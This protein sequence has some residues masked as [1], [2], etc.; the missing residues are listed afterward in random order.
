MPGIYNYLFFYVLSRKCL[1]AT[2]LIVISFDFSTHKF[3]LQ[4]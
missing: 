3:Q 1:R 4:A 2:F